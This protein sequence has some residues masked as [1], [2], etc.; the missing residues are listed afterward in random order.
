M[1]S[2][3]FVGHKKMI[4]GTFQ[5]NMYYGVTIVSYINC[6][7]QD[8]YQR[9]LAANLRLSWDD[10]KVSSHSFIDGSM[11]IAK[12]DNCTG[13]LFAADGMEASES[14][15][16]CFLH[17]ELKNGEGINIFGA[18]TPRSGQQIQS[19]A[20]FR[21]L[22]GRIMCLERRVLLEENGAVRILRCHSD[23][24]HEN[25]V[26]FPGPSSLADMLP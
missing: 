22:D 17:E 2:R 14:D 21:H 15:L 11:I 20:H 24:E 13:Y 4:N 12:G 5:K 7:P 26:P 9:L 16:Y 8:F 18:Y 19:R 25:V 10:F 23:F 1:L 3:C 6:D